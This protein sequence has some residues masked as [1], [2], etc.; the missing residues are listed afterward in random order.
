MRSSPWTFAALASLL[1]PAVVVADPASVASLARTDLNATSFT[2]ADA[3]PTVSLTTPLVAGVRYRP[4]GYYRDERSNWYMP[5][6]T[7]LHAGFLDPTDNFGTSFDGGVRIGPMVDPHIQLGVGLDWWHRSTS[8]TANLGSLPLPGGSA[9][10]QIELS[11]STADLVPL[12]GFVQV[13]GD[14]DMPVVPYGGAGI[15]Y[16]WLIVHAERADTGDTFDQTFGGFGWQAWVGAGIPLSGH[17]RVNGEVFYNGSEPRAD[18]ILDDGTPATAK[19]NMNG[20]GMRFG[21]AWGF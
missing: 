4:R 14:E 5:T 1:L 12:L 21:I 19:V 10:A 7:Q 15:G 17:A 20:V 8:E 13:S 16:E 3:A 18:V 2:A 11:R 9:N 6:W